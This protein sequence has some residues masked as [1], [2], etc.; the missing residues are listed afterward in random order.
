MSNIWFEDLDKI[1]I[2]VGYFSNQDE[3]REYQKNQFSKEFENPIYSDE[4]E[5]VTHFIFSNK[6]NDL[7]E[8]IGKLNCS[9]S[10]IQK[11]TEGIQSAGLEK[12]NSSIVIFW[13]DKN[14][15]V[16]SEKSR[17]HCVF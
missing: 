7:V 10:Y 4:V 17:W 14:K 2:W 5:E 12:F 1:A 16:Y 3:F 13:I 11:V 9:K 6:D 15:E 8:L